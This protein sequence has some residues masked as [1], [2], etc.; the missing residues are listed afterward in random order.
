V[1]S[2]PLVSALETTIAYQTGSSY[3]AVTDSFKPS[4]LSRAKI[5][6]SS[7]VLPWSSNRAQFFQSGS[8]SLTMVS[9]IMMKL[10][11]SFCYVRGTIF[12][13]E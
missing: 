4:S 9:L 11:W 2:L 8:G 7:G 6:R 3:L 10:L 1:I 12:V 13:Y 5:D